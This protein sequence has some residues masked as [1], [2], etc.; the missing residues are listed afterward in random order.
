MQFQTVKKCQVPKEEEEQVPNGVDFDVPLQ[1]DQS[2]ENYIQVAV[3]RFS[4][5]LT[6][7]LTLI[8]TNISRTQIQHSPATWQMRQETLG[9][10]LVL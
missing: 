4:K 8:L 7:F 5:L 9:L 1:D 3:H 10:K 2:Q 6:Q